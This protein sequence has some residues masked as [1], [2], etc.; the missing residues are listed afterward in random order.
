MSADLFDQSIPAFASASE[1]FHPIYT[2]W[3]PLPPT[4]NLYYV[5]FTRV[6]KHGDKKG[7]V[8]TGRG[9][10][11]DGQAFAAEVF[12]RVREGHRAPPKLGGRLA[13]VVV[14]FPDGARVRFDLDNRLKPLQDALQKA[15]VFVDDDSQIDDLRIMRG[16]GQRGGGSVVVFSRFDPDEVQRAMARAGS[17]FYSPD[18]R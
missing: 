12:R 6:G 17:K 9:I 1:L 10:S 3:L 18:A 16:P 15:G 5:N 14:V 8:Y 13:L 4:V 7:K 11:D 2:L